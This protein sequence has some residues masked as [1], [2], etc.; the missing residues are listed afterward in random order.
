MR[1]NGANAPFADI[2]TP[3]TVILLVVA[4]LHVPVCWVAVHILDLGVVGG[5]FATGSMYWTA[6]LLTIAYICF[7]DGG[8]AW[9]RPSRGM[10]KDLTSFAKL[11]ILGVMMV[12]A[13]WS[14]S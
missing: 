14:V 12:G 6:C 1:S 2:Q 7:V 3:G 13:E 8:Q 4:I 11:A 5:A 10:F 9:A